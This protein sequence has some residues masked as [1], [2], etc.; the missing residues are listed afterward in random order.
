LESALGEV[1]PAGKE[2]HGTGKLKVTHIGPDDD[3]RGADILIVPDSHLGKAHGGFG[4]SRWELDC[5]AGLEEA[6]EIGIQHQVDAI[7]HLGDIFHNDTD[8]GI[9]DSIGERCRQV[10][11]N[12][13]NEQIPFYYIRGNHEKKEGR[14]WMERFEDSGLA[15]HLRT[16]PLVI[17][18]SIAVYGIDYADS[19]SSDLLAFDR[20]PS[21]AIN[22]LCLHQSLA[23]LTGNSNPDCSAE[24]IDLAAI[25]VGHHHKPAAEK[26]AGCLVFCSGATE[27][28]GAKPDDPLPSVDLLSV[29]NNELE[30]RRILLDGRA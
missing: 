5:A 27:R 19:W 2:L 15:S 22:L 29:E 10:L 8:V 24:E 17:N 23:P 1:W 13:A 25:A 9:S 4:A 18:D 14:I 21:N 28:F 30:R 6:I 12:L 3:G 16:R 11:S 26:I 7:I 20:P